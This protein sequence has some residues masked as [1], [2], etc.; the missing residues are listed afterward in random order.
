LFAFIEII[1]LW[2]F[3]LLTSI[4]LYK[5]SKPAAYLL[6]PYIV[7]V[8]FAAVLNFSIMVLN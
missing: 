7:W 6:I 5:I 4:K 3:I 8:T 2:S 1:L